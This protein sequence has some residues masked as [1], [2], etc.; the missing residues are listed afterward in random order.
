MTKVK[1]LSNYK[2]SSEFYVIPSKKDIKFLIN[3]D[4]WNMLKGL[5]Q[6]LDYPQLKWYTSATI[7]LCLSLA[8]IER[9]ISDSNWIFPVIILFVISVFCFFIHYKIEPKILN[10]NKGQV[11]D[12]VD[13]IEK[14]LEYKEM[15]NI[16]KSEGP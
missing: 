1:K 16:Y 15:E 2:Y 6:K 3:M 11:D 12:Y 14:K 10:S 8:F 4:D 7:T 5:I 13:N 9:A